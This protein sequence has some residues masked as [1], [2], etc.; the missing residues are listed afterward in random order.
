PIIVT[1]KTQSYKFKKLNVGEIVV[2]SQNIR[3]LYSNST[4]FLHGQKE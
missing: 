4:T 1:N 3:Y 2:V